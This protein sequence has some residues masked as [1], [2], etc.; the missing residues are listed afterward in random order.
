MVVSSLPLPFLIC[1]MFLT[2]LNSPKLSE[3]IYIYIQVKGWPRFKRGCVSLW[4]SMDYHTQI[5]NY[6]VSN[7]PQSHI[8]C[9]EPKLV[10]CRHG[11]I[12]SH[13]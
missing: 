9:K 1:G 2:P 10:M 5:L 6:G 7:N 13:N 4:A 12:E 11:P 3:Y 8:K